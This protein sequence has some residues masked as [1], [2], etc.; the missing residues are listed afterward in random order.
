MDWGK[1]KQINNW[2]HAYRERETDTE[3][4]LYYQKDRGFRQKPKNEKGAVF[5]STGFA[6]ARRVQLKQRGRHKKKATGVGLWSNPQVIIPVQWLLM[7]VSGGEAWPI[8]QIDTSFPD[9]VGPP[10]HPHVA[11]LVLFSSH[12][13]THKFEWCCACDANENTLTSARTKTSDVWRSGHIT[14]NK[15]KCW[16]KVDVSEDPWRQQEQEHIML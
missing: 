13:R 12:C 2:T 9:I 14:E 10:S 6:P 16:S 5:R 11:L 7:W 15:F 4:E 8:V 3:T 1:H